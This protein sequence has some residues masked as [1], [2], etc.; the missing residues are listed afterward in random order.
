[1][2]TKHH[3]ATAENRRA[4]RSACPPPRNAWTSNAKS[5]PAHS[6]AASK[7]MSRLLVA[8][9]CEPPVEEWP[10]SASGISVI[11]APPNSSGVGDQRSIG[12]LAT[13]TIAARTAVHRQAPA[14]ATRLATDQIA[15]GLS[16]DVSG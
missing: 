2:A 11:R 7:W 1:M 16:R 14:V 10:V 5:P 4:A 12:M 3:R 6:A 15:D 13:V 9:S 8:R